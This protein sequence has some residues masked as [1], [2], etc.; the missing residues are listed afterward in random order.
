MQQQDE[1]CSK[2]KTEAEGLD[3]RKRAAELPLQEKMKEGNGFRKWREGFENY[4][5][6]VEPGM[7]MIL[8]NR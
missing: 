8:R 6:I 2:E 3:E 7:K 4:C 1:Q 5:E